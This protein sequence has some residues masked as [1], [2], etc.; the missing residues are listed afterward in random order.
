MKTRILGLLAG[1]TLA[2][3]PAQAVVVHLTDPGTAHQTNALTGFTTSGNQ[4]AGMDV[5]VTFSDSSTKQAVWA[6]TGGTSGG[7]TVANWFSFSQTGD[8]FSNPWTLTNLSS[9]AITGFRFYGAPGDAIFD[10]G[11]SP[12]TPGSENGTLFSFLTAGF[13]ATVT[14]SDI[15]NLTANAPSGDLYVS[16]K[17]DFGANTLLGAGSSVQFRQDVDSA[18]VPNSIVTVPDVSTTGLLAGLAMLGLVGLKRRF[19][20]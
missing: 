3:I 15:F 2:S 18:A 1:L 17:V 20:V 6:N 14:Y 5:F 19:A 7:A 10:L 9:L 8:T 13:D 11:T 4:I 12:S 16:M